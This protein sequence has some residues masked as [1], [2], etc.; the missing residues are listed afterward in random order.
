VSIACSGAA[1][2]FLATAT[3]NGGWLSVSPFSGNTPATLSVS[4][5]SI[6]LAAGSYSGSVS[7]SSAT[8]GAAPVLPV[9]VIVSPAP[10]P[11]PS[12]VPTITPSSLSFNYQTGSA[13]PFDQTISLGGA[14]GLIFTAT[15]SSSGWLAVNPSGAATPANLTVA[16]NPAALS[17]GTYSGVILIATNTGSMGTS[18][19]VAVTLTVSTAAAPPIV[20]PIPNITSLVNAASL[21][22]TPLAPGEIISFF[23]RGLG[24]VESAQFRLTPGGLIDNSLVG[25]RVLIDGTP[26]PIVYTQAG[27]VN[28]IVP[29]SVAGKST[30]QVMVEYQGVRSASGSFLVAAA[31][32]AIF[33]TDGSGH[34]QGAI[35]DQDTSV[36]SDLNPA[37]RG[38]IV[39]LYATGA[40][41]MDP[42]GIDGA[43]TGT[44]LARP[45]AAVSVLVDGQDTEVLYAG[46]APGLVAGVLQVNFRLPSQVR[47]GAAVGVLLKVGRFTSQP[48]VTLAVR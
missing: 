10:A 24:P 42:G 4:V 26:A 45:V 9:T 2:Q 11:V 48:G 37:D 36:N 8:C 19:S 46:A 44:N 21:L 30:V 1:G 20:I 22:A 33:T 14:A 3:S 5:N 15:A 28:A 25:T 13:N 41:Q 47:T 35:L 18:Q 6:G 16:V 40:G 29:Y 39:V 43:I 23:G 34:G 31:A 17:P 38:S 12:P 27:Q 32:P 7:A